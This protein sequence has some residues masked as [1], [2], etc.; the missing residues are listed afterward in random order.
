[1]TMINTLFVVILSNGKNIWKKY[2]GQV[3]RE[4]RTLVSFR[5]HISLGKTQDVSSD[6]G[7]AITD[8][9]YVQRGYNMRLCL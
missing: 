2:I 6:S 9:S 3:Q 8:G 7:I 4:H 5:N 1:M